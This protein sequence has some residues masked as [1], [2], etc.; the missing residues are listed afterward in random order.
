MSTNSVWI[1]IA[2]VV[3]VLAIAVLIF[4]VSGAT[5][6]RRRRRA[7]EIREQAK[8][9]TAR[10]DRRQALAS[11][12]AAKARAAQAEAEAKAAEASRLQEQAASHQSEAAT[13]REELQ[14]QF[15]RAD[16]IDPTVNKETREDPGDTQDRAWGEESGDYHQSSNY[17]ASS[18]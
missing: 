14:E 16:S 2:A 5:R 18:S 1:V 12:T 10:V 9:D 7:E 4:A 6:R 11:E 13:S 8:L 3:A 17:R 15:K